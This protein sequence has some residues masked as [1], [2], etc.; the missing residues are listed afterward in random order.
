MAGILLSSEF[1]L[2]CYLSKAQ[3]VLEFLRN[4]E[5]CVEV[6]HH[7][8]P[9]LIHC[10][11]SAQLAAAILSIAFDAAV[12]V[13]T[14]YKTI[15]S[16]RSASRLDMQHGLPYFLARDGTCLHFQVPKAHGVSGITESS[17]SYT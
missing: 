12:I 1:L 15:S 3:E 6:S 10:M 14:L 7:S 9:N 11:I 13:L 17:L 4:L 16:V 5:V 8:K 2:P